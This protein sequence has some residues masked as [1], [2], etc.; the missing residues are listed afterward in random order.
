MSVS[1]WYPIV[2]ITGPRQSGKSTLCRLVRPD[3]PYVNL[4]SPAE[5]A[6]WESDPL[7][8]IRAHP[9]GAILDEFQRLPDLASALQVEVDANPAPGRWLLTGSENLAVRSSVAQS[10][11]GRSG[12]VHLLP[13]T[14]VERDAFR[15]PAK[16]IW[17][18]VFT[19]GYPRIFDR[20]IP[21]PVWLADYV[22]TYVTR[23]ARDIVKVGNTATYGTFLQLAAGRTAQELN[24]ASLGS[25]TGITQ[26][27]AR[28][29]L[30]TLESMWL[31]QR[32]PRWAVNVTSQAVKAPKLHFLD[33][34]LAC[35]LLGIREASQL[36]T[37]P[38]RG[39]IFESWV[40]SEL[41]KRQ[42][43]AGRP[44]DLHHFRD[45]QGVE[46]DLVLAGPQATC[47]VEVKS[48]ETPDPG[49][50]LRLHRFAGKLPG[51]AHRL[52]IHA[53]DKTV[54][55]ERGTLLSW[56]DLDVAPELAE[57]FGS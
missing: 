3:L 33:T 37:H 11:A 10:L 48:S 17:E 35:N 28:S 8:M 43:N 41:T 50:L 25:D 21:A 13:L 52:V 26:P 19:G 18:R 53:G 30:S 45:A 44:S 40:A 16:D 42:M 57:W 32:L 4:E 47:L 55:T 56:R 46:V 29:W 49:A 2:V 54:R 6:L 24:L 15:P 22:A 7:G 1:G 5:R 20:R 12:H 31:V 23:D 14:T 36:V 27:T 9:A 39:A 51:T 34:G 38:L